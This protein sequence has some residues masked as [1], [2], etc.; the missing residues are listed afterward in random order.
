MHIQPL[1]LASASPRRRELLRYLTPHFAVTATLGE[2]QDRSLPTDLVAA[3]PAFPLA[4]STHPSLLAWRKVMAAL[5]EGATGLVLGAD[6]IVVIDYDV[7]NKPRDED[8]ARDML[9]RLAGRTHR[10][11]TGVVTLD[12]R[13]GRVEFALDASDVQMAA[14]SADEIADYVATGEPMD[15]AGAYGIQGLGGRLVQQ[16]RGSYTCVVGLPLTTT[17][18]MLTAMGLSEL[19]DPAVAFERWLADHGRRP[20]ACTAP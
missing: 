12:S 20:P 2:E 11:Y 8:E 4:Q 15:K 1:L 17:H 3:L 13:S 9:R 16:V 6:T 14:L 19:A 7:L 18:R 5:D 10:V